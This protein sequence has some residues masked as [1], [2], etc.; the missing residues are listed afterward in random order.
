MSQETRVAGK[1]VVRLA[2]WWRRASP[3][4]WECP[5]CNKHIG[6][7]SESVVILAAEQHGKEAH[8]Q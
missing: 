3:W 1:A 6:G 7:G 5:A 2:A 4:A 8:D